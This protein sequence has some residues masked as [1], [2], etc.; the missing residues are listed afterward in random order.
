VVGQNVRRRDRLRQP[1]AYVAQPL[2][3]GATQP[4]DRQAR[5]HGHEPPFGRDDVVVLRLIPAQEGFLHEVFGFL[6]VTQHPIRDSEEPRAVVLGVVYRGKVV[7][8]HG[9]HTVDGT[10]NAL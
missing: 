1:V 7:A 5:D 3:L 2:G 8:E 6:H 4:V 9:H 10:V